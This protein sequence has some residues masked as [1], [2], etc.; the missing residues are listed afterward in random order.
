MADKHPAKER[1]LLGHP[2][3]K[4][5]LFMGLLF[6][7]W[8]AGWFAIARF[9]DGKVGEALAN[10][11]Q[12]GIEISCSDRDIVGFPFRMG[13]AC[14]SVDVADDVHDYALNAGGLRSAAQIYSPRKNVVEIA[15]PFSFTAQ[16]QEVNATW[17]MMRV[18]IAQQGHGFDRLSLNWTDLK[19]QGLNG[20]LESSAGALHLRPN[21]DAVSDLDVAGN[22][23]DL[24]VNGDASL[25]ASIAYDTVLKAAYETIIE[26]RKRPI[27][28]LKDGG[29][30][31]VRSLFIVLPDGGRLALSG[32]LKVSADGMLNG[33]VNFGLDDA[34]ALAKFVAEINPEFG[35]IVLGLG[36]GINMLGSETAFGERSIKAV[37]VNIEDGWTQIGPLKL[38]RIPPIF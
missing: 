8:F 33:S 7:V 27:D 31:N 11:E 22:W 15:S 38:G 12:R 13:I 30:I 5:G 21:P 37:T 17:N 9:A 6:V 36:Q 4:W 19:A 25:R 29:E 18:F 20:E 32:P 28:W 10:L 16:G 24:V 14:S 23:D 34:D 2:M 26:Q 1:S 35:P 3:A